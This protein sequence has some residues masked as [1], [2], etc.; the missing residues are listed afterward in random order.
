[1]ARKDNGPG[2]RQAVKTSVPLDKVT[3]A[4]LCALA[5]LRGVDRSILSAQFIRAGL[6]GVSIVERHN[7]GGPEPDDDVAA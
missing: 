2:D 3:H 6:R 4:R 7:A 1:M 5:A